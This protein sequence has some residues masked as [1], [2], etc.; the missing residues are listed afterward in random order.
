MKIIHGISRQQMQFTSLDDLIAADNPVRILDTFVE[1]LDL[2]MLGIQQIKAIQQQS[3]KT[4]PGGARSRLAAGLIF[5]DP[6]TRN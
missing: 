3:T 2:G 5:R 6:S 1:K 4:N